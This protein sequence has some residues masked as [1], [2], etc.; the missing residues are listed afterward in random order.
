MDDMPHDAKPP[1]DQRAFDLAD[2]VGFL[3]SSLLRPSEQKLLEEKLL[4]A[5]QEV[6]VG[7]GLGLNREQDRFGRK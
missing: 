1:F 7:L 6:I 4:S 3:L 5:P 2:D